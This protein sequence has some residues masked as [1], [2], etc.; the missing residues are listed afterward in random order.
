[1]ANS[2]KG[3]GLIAV[4]MRRFETRWLPET[5]LI[6]EKVDRG[7]VLTDWALTFLEEVIDDIS[8]AQPLVEQHPEFKALY[9][10]VAGLYLEIA[11]KALKNESAS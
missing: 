4:M 6:K 3:D 9:G 5:L 7:E 10:R 1:M 8:E 11:E 2:T